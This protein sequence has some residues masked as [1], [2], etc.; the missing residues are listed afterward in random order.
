MRLFL[1]EFITGGGLWSRGERPEGSL[2]AEGAAMAVALANDLAGIDGVEVTVLCDT[3]L[4]AAELQYSPQVRRIAVDSAAEEQR[5]VFF[6]AKTSDRVWL[7]A[8]EFDGILCELIDWVSVAD[9][10]SLVS[11]Q[12]DFAEIAADKQRTAETLAAAGV[13]TPRGCLWTGDETVTFPAIV[14]PNDGC[15]SQGVCRVTS[16]EELAA[17]NPR[18]RRVEEELHGQAVSCAVLCGMDEV[19]PLPACRQHLSD[20]GRFTYLGG[21]L[22]L[23]AE[24]NARAQSLAVAA[25]RALRKTRGYVGVDLILGE[26]DA[27]I[28]INPRL[29]TSY[30]GLR[31]AC[32]QNLAEWILKVAT[33][34]FDAADLAAMS[35]SPDAIKFAADGTVLA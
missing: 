12:R 8:P 30:V 32:R 3:R 9:G 4:T 16:A 25:V 31:R 15:G 1:Y 20:D 28:E 23:S 7:I 22:P 14:K 5:Q 21:S 11:P 10:G 24:E 13:R 29:T 27:V 34:D 2:L 17:L 35:F 6:C 26:V 33:L 18:G 19:F